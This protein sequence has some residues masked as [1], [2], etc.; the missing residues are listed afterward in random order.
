MD[1]PMVEAI[2][3]VRWDGIQQVRFSSFGGWSGPALEIAKTLERS[4][5]PIILS[6][7]C[8]SACLSVLV[9]RTASLSP[10]TL[11]L[12]HNSPIAQYYAVYRK[13]PK[14]GLFLKN[15][16]EGDIDWL[17]QH[18]VDPRLLLIA[19]IETGPTCVTTDKDENSE[20]SAEHLLTGVKYQL[21]APSASALK[22]FGVKLR[23]APLQDAER[24]K[25]EL[26]RRYPKADLKLVRA[27]DGNLSPQLPPF[28]ALAA[29]LER[30]PVCAPN[31]LQGLRLYG[32]KH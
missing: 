18:G 28:G 20:A 17:I 3:R 9:L 27:D 16:G 1:Q 31:S 2:R 14:L 21:W 5:K 26:A 8:A 22:N 29:V 10:K 11:V 25:I 30:I 13:Y 32:S 7:V 19:Y 23:G 12:L 6:D 24:A 4:G 15:Y